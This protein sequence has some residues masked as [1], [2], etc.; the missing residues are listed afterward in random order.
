[1]K[2]NRPRTT[3]FT[4]IE[5]MIVVAI[6]GILAA[7]AIPAFLKNA[8]KAKTTEATVNVKKLHDGGIA[9]Y[10]G[11]RNAAGSVT[12]IAKQFPNTPVSGS[13]EPTTDCCNAG[14][15]GAVG[16]KCS[17][18]P[19]FWSDPEWNELGFAMT[20]PHYYQYRYV[21]RA[22][23][24]SG[25]GAPTINGNPATEYFY[26]DALGNLNCDNVYSTF[27]MFGAV[28]QDGS[29]T[30]GGGLFKNLELE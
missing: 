19:S 25:A 8:L 23:G 13:T 1:M 11:D 21:R 9:Y 22:A 4:L 2:K 29:T 10:L 24:S 15:P 6:I 5:L 27:E 16:G 28:T 18:Q 7:V 30:S 3:G 26:A 14:T 12:P 20:D 17:P